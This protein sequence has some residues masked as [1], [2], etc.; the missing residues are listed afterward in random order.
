ME[1]IKNERLEFIL[2]TLNKMS[3]ISETG[4]FAFRFAKSERTLSFGVEFVS[5]KNLK[6]HF[7]IRQNY[8]YNFL[9]E[10]I[11]ECCNMFTREFILFCVAGK[12]LTEPVYDRFGCEIISISVADLINKGL[13]DE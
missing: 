8:L 1:S 10:E 5:F 11:E 3:M 4:C 6:K 2:D 12:T 13:E 9:N 7:V